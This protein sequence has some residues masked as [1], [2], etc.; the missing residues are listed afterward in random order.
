[1]LDED[2]AETRVALDAIERAGEQALGEMRRLLGM[3]RLADE[4]A[5]LTPQPGLGRLGELAAEVTA[6]GLPVD[7]R[8][9]GDV[10][11]L[12]PGVDV[13]AYRIV[14]EALTNALKHAGPARATVV[15]RY[16]PDELE[17][18]IADDG[19]GT[20]DGGGGGS[21]QGLVGIRERVGFYG[22]ELAAGPDPGGGFRVWARLPVPAR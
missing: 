4:R 16:V 2:P 13:S 10:V 9:E 8:V 5:A 15:L 6:A 19:A 11:E 20:G 1:M 14:Q 22:G 18:E 17:L 12:P 3:L 7:V 21:G